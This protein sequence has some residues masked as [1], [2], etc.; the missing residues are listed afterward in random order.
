VGRT[1]SDGTWWKWKIDP[2]TVDAVLLYAQRGHG[3]R[4]SLYTDYTFAVW[5]EGPDGRKLVPFAKAYS[6][7]TDEEILEVDAI[8]RRTTV[9]KFGPVRSVAPTLVFELG[10]EAIQRSPRHKSGIAVRFPRMLRWRADKP[11]EGRLRSTLTSPRAT[12]SMSDDH[13]R[14]RAGVQCTRRWP[15]RSAPARYK[16]P[17]GTTFD[18]GFHA[19]TKL[20]LAVA[21]T[22]FWPASPARK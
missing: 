6:G 15:T 13:G 11:V 7:L 20:T 12:R 9:E 10:F 8:V 1:K 17:V 16:P 19:A 21:A 18:G 3:R 22:L 14:Q 5:D 2:M 4:A